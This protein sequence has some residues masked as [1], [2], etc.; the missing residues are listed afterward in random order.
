ML[1]CGSGLVELKN[2]NGFNQYLCFK[3][4]TLINAQSNLRDSS[5]ALVKIIAKQYKYIGEHGVDYIE[6]NK[7]LDNSQMYFKCHLVKRIR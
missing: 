7:P 6:K 4:T 5:I 1:V 3:L 2:L